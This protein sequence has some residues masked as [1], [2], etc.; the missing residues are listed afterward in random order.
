VTKLD[1]ELPN[2]R[3]CTV[4]RLRMA[5]R[6]LSNLYDG[7]LAP[8]GL[9][10]TQVSILAVIA[11]RAATPPTIKDLSAILVMDRSTMGQNLRPLEREGLVELAED[12]TDRRIRRVVLTDAGRARLKIASAIWA[13]AQ[14]RVDATYGAGLS[15]ELRELLQRIN[16]TPDPD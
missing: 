14:A 1:F 3:D 15:A 7:M 2:L 9:K 10:N 6:R 12:G 11:T 5:S 8:S 13:Q 4:T 16:A